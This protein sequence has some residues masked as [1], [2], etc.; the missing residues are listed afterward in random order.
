MTAYYHM[1]I[2]TVYIRAIKQSVGKTV[3]ALPSLRRFQNASACHPTDKQTYNVWRNGYCSDP[4]RQT[5]LGWKLILFVNESTVCRLATQTHMR[6]S[7]HART[8]A[9]T[10][11]RTHARTNE[12]TCTKGHTYN[13]TF[14]PTPTLHLYIHTYT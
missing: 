9:R 6:A 14:I 4:L 12:E 5:W 7:A 11:V 13:H 8:H 1:Y 3:S 10:H 2:S